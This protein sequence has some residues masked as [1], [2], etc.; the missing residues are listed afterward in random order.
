MII[1]LIA[2]SGR[3]CGVEKNCSGDLNRRY[4]ILDLE[5]N[6]IDSLQISLRLAIILFAVMSL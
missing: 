6:S 2:N 4:C 3:T 5:R 1:V